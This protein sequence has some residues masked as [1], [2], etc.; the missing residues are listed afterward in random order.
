MRTLVLADSR[1]Y[2]PA[3]VEGL[4]TALDHND[5]E[6]QEWATVALR[7][8]RGNPEAIDALWDCFRTDSRHSVRSCALIALGHLGK[9]LGPDEL[10]ALYGERKDHPKDLVLESAIRW[11]GR[12]TG[13]PEMLLALR[14]IQMAEVARVRR[15]PRLQATILAA[16]ARCA[17]GGLA[18]GTLTKPWLKERGFDDLL[19]KLGETRIA[20][21]IAEEA[22]RNAQPALEGLEADDHTESLVPGMPLDD[23]VEAQHIQDL[24]EYAN[25]RLRE[26]RTFVRDRALALEAKRRAQFRC[27]VCGDSLGDTEAARRYVQAHHVEPLSVFGP[28]VQQNLVVLCPSCHAKMHAGVMTLERSADGVR[29]VRREEATAGS[30]EAS[31]PVTQDS[32]RDRLL[33]LFRELDADTQETVI[34]ELLAIAA[35][36]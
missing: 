14:G 3:I 19:G 16:L 34:R 18:G 28:D 25:V 9:G 20:R 11:A 24:A 27:E 36:P 7:G 8:L 5:Y 13:T 12:T 10:R 30:R 33:A 17:R 6:I 2:D 31:S 21:L 26:Q 15:E 4:V 32:V 29:V 1:K 35:A 22:A 23:A